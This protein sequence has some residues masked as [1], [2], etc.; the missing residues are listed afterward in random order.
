MQVGYAF[1]EGQY[2]GLSVLLQVNNLTNTPYVTSQSPQIG[3][4]NP[5][6]VLPLTYA[7][8]GRTVLLGM[9]YKF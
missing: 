1:D 9:N 5:S 4:D 6:G 2:K 7:T 8:Y 3:G